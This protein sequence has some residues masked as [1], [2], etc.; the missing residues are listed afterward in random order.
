MHIEHV[1]DSEHATREELI[2]LYFLLHKKT[3]VR[4]KYYMEFNFK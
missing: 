1:T 3:A 2:I 4:I